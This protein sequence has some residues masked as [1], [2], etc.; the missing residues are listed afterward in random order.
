MSTTAGWIEKLQTEEGALVF[1]S[2]NIYEE[3]VINSIPIL[4]KDITFKY[5]QFY[6]GVKIVLPEFSGILRFESCK[7]SSLEFASCSFTGHG[8]LYIV[9]SNVSS[10]FLINHCSSD[11]FSID[12]I[13]GKF[14]AISLDNCELNNCRIIFSDV[15]ASYIECEDL[16]A[17]AVFISS[18]NRR[19]K[20]GNMGF[21]RTTA[22]MLNISNSSIAQLEMKMVA[23]ETGIDFD[24]N[25]IDRF[26]FDLPAKAYDLDFQKTNFTEAF[27]IILFDSDDVFLEKKSGLNFIRIYNCDLSKNG[28]IAGNS[29]ALCTVEG[30]DINGTVVTESIL[31]ISDLRVNGLRL[32]Y[33]R[34]VK[35]LRLSN[36]KVG[37]LS[38]VGLRNSGELNFSNLVPYGDNLTLYISSSQ[39]GNWKL[40]DCNLK[41][42]K[43]VVIE[44]S[45]L[46]GLRYASVEW[47]N[48]EA[49][50]YDGG[51]S[52]P[53]V[54]YT[55]WQRFKRNYFERVP[56]EDREAAAA[57]NRREVYRMLKEAAE[58]QKDRFRSLRF[59]QEEMKA[60]GEYLR[61]TQ[62]FYSPERFV[63]WAGNSN[64]HGLN[65]WKP[66]LFAVGF[67]LLFFIIL[68]YNTD[69][70]ML[71][72][73][74]FSAAGQ[75]QLWS[76]WGIIP[77]MMNPVH[78][79]DKMFP[80]IK[81]IPDFSWLID[82][83]HRLLMAFFIV[84]TVSAFRKYMKA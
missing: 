61:L 78:A 71:R 27:E 33:D 23:V 49:L 48:R 20:K 30:I 42:F 37:T 60:Q 77:Q 31:T 12:I 70:Q 51:L 40:I 72:K 11:D 54:T 79:F 67:T 16:I 81:S 6:K 25:T 26:Y 2:I 38:M 8:E 29:Q 64:N 75:E 80:G 15:V 84:Q 7:F 62:R 74:F 46:L 14:N 45:D 63:F 24:S 66:V 50:Q 83:L 32:A 56:R 57:R 53:V 36:L 47:F 82:Y 34:S 59:Q 19:G 10:S 18:L 5:I 44:N 58:N 76:H 3:L 73:T 65:W 22:E 1:E 52:A 69:P 39:P 17:D 43:R 55:R 21:R 68:V 4:S 35:D 41:A 28:R 9:D 13:R